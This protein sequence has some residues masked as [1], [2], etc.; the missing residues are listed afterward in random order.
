MEKSITRKQFFLSKESETLSLDKRKPE[1][2]NIIDKI[3]RI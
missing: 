3:F 1:N 2:H